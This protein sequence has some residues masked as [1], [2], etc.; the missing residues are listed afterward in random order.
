[1]ASTPAVL[2]ARAEEA[3]RALYQRTSGQANDDSIADTAEVHQMLGSLK[4]VVEN[5][6]RCL[7]ELNTWLEQRMWSGTLGNGGELSFD[8]LTKSTFEVAAALARAH[9]MSAQLGRELQAAQ[10]ASRDL[11]TQ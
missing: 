3:A 1:M 9:R 10:T 4:L 6:A 7:P 5:L 2:A 11:A 8:E